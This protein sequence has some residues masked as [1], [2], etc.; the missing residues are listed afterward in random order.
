[1]GRA[2]DILGLPLTVAAV[3][4]EVLLTAIADGIAVEAWGEGSPTRAVY[5]SLAELGKKL[6]DLIGEIADQGTLG[7]ASDDG[8]TLRAEEVYTI[9]RPEADFATTTLLITNTGGGVYPWSPDSP[10]IL[11]STIRKKQYIT[12][13]SGEVGVLAVNVPMDV[14]A[15]DPG[16]AS[17]ALPG[18]IDAWVSPVDGLTITQ[19][20]PA[21]GQDRMSDDNLK[22][23]CSA[24][25]GFIPTESTIGAGG[26]ST[27]YESVARTGIDGKGGVPRADGSRITVTRVVDI[28]DGAG[29]IIVYLA[30]ADGA[31]AAPDLALV[32]AAILAHA[33]PVGIPVAVLNATNLPISCSLTC[34]IGASTTATDTEVRA[35]ISSALATYLASVKIGG[36]AISG[37]IVPIR[38]G[39]EDAA[40]D[41]AKTVTKTIK[42]QF[43]TPSADVPIAPNEVPLFVL[44]TIAINRVT[45]S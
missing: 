4:R 13:G 7:S 41:G 11:A 1:M 18:E 29:G 19:L 45:G 28:P 14:I 6:G 8:L 15:I 21:I 10:L 31:I 32:E 27:A 16:S 30:D 36:F 44:G 22:A 26:A 37:G 34:W 43:G 40:T 35:A 20:S 2:A 38:G 24:R 42:V 17:T 39:L 3:L 25:V 33:K 23:A 9:T 12:Q 5:R